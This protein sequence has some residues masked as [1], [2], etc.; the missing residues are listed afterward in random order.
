M[1]KWQKRARERRHACELNRVTC[2]RKLQRLQHASSNYAHLWNLLARSLDARQTTLEEI[3]ERVPHS[4]EQVLRALTFATRMRSLERHCEE[5]V[6]GSASTVS[7]PSLP[8]TASPAGA[9]AHLRHFAV[10]R[11]LR[12]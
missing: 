9:S 10:H 3:L 1:N 6:T 5:Q 8:G 2:R 7:S 12:I 11:S 4:R